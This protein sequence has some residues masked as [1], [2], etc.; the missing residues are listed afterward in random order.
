MHSINKNKKY[1]YIYSKKKL[2]TFVVFSLQIENEL[3]WVR[4]GKIY[5][6]QIANYNFEHLMSWPPMIYSL[7]HSPYNTKLYSLSIC[8]MFVFWYD[9]FNV[10]LCTPSSGQWAK[11]V[12]MG[13]VVIVITKSRY[14]L[15]RRTGKKNISVRWFT[16][17]CSFPVEIRWFVWRSKVI[18]ERIG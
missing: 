14:C 1:L 13:F 6:I 8:H 4:Y 12:Y 5:Q 10:M 18:N 15:C 2:C 17:K 11:F 9:I 7:A 3:V 16:T